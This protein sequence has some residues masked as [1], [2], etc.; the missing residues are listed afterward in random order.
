VPVPFDFADR[1]SAPN[2]ELLGGHCEE[3][4]FS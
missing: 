2:R 1:Q 4:Q 3:F